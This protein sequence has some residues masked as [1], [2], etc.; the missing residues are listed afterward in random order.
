MNLK[1]Y[2]FKAALNN[3][4]MEGKINLGC[5]YFEI[6]LLKDFVKDSLSVEE[7]FEDIEH[8]DKIDIL[9]VHCPLDKDEFYQGCLYLEYLTDFECKKH[10]IKTCHFAQ[11]CANYYKHKI[12]VI[13]HN[14]ITFEQLN[15]MPSLKKELI[16]L[17]NIIIILY[18]DIYI[19]IENTTPF[20]NKNPMYFT[21]GIFY[22]NCQIVRYFNEVCIE[23]VFKTVFDICHYLTAI[24]VNE[25]I[26]PAYV[27]LESLFIENEDVL[28]T[29]HF[30]NLKN[31]GIQPFEHGCG[32]TESEEDNSRLKEILKYIDKYAY[33]ADIC[34]EISEKDYYNIPVVMQTLKIIDKIENKLI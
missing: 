21:A 34:M 19:E 9:T 15:L 31:L 29:V 23:P 26:C 12:K 28:G 24:K 14:G 11:L 13:I 27:S 3:K 1:K 7:I 5:Y 30:A 16:E 2:T 33:N 6:Q 17:M 18:P 25:L 10:F 32:Y 4:E 20:V 22:E 8:K